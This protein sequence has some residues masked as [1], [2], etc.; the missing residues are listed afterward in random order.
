MRKM[1][2]SALVL[3]ALLAIFGSG[4]AAFARASSGSTGAASAD[5]MTRLYAH[6]DFIM[7]SKIGADIKPNVAG[8]RPA[9]IKKAYGI[10]LLKNKGAGIT[11]A[12]VDACGN[13]HA[14]SDLNTYD[15]KFN[16]PATTIKI[17]TPQGTP[18]S[19]PTG[20][21][22]ETD[23]DIQMVHAVAPQATIVLEAAK[24]ASF[25]NLINAAKDAYTN[26]GA[27]IVS[28]SFGGSEFSG[29]TGS[30]ADGVFSSGNAKGVSFTASSG[31]SGC[32][33]QY[34]AA[35]PFVTSVGGTSLTLSSTG[36][37]GSE[38]AWSGSGGG[39]SAFESRPSYQSGFNSVNQRGIPDVAMV[40][41][42]NTGVIMYDSDVGGY[43]EV[44][45]TSV[46]APL[47]AGVLAITDQ[48]RT[49][50]MQN[51]DNELY[52]VASNATKYAGNYHDITTGS[53]GGSCAAKTGYDLVTGLGSPVANKL[54]PALVAAP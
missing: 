45:G 30:T 28:M 11:V 25:A 2:G 23:L 7:K 4:Y 27:T 24:S 10:N 9:Q 46:A 38:S 50:S 31:D 16:L 49:S 29:E 32:G 35:S 40:A 20:W 17:V 18:C 15:T 21:G 5:L 33:A 54:V 39:L 14:Q 47:W 43:I 36:G 34:P 48:G 52:N 53:A 44:G 22:V 8:F 41:D 3:I 26:Q 42:P 12:I 51:A 37:Y 1:T 13:S 6:Y 19:D